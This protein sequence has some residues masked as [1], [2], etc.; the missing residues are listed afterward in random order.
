MFTVV[1]NMAYLG[2]ERFIGLGNS[3]GNHI[4]GGNG[5]DADNG[6]TLLGF[7]GSDRLYG[8]GGGDYLAGGEGNDGMDGGEGN[9]IFVMDNGNAIGGDVAVG[10]NGNDTVQADESVA[11]T[12]L[13]LNLFARGTP[14]YGDVNLV[15]HTSAAMEVEL[16][17]GG[18]GND[19]VDASRL[20]QPAKRCFKGAKAMTP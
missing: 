2:T 8:F 16:V 3:V 14:V 11:A 7:G 10:G 4:N 1:E 20:G 18:I 13:R 6:D 17:Q 5:G 12:G 15:P 19:H 9:D